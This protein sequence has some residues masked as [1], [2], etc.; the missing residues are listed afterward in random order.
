M[1]AHY[2]SSSPTS[3]CPSCGLR[4]DP[5]HHK[6][7]RCGQALNDAPGLIYRH[8]ADGTWSLVR[9]IDLASFAPQPAPAPKKRLS[10]RAAML[11]LLLVVTGA[12]IN[13][14]LWRRR[15]VAGR[16]ESNEISYYLTHPVGT[17]APRFALQY[18][19]TEQGQLRMAGQTNLPDG[20][21]LQVEVYAGDLMVAIDF[22][23]AV[24]AGQFQTRAL[25]Q[26]GKPFVLAAYQ[27][28][29]SATFDR[30]SQPP[31]VLLVVGERGERLRGPLIHRVDATSGATLRYVENFSLSQ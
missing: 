10:R 27:A 7:T 4:Q 5:G 31:P 16:G 6:C 20:T 25:L 19:R 1:P 12:T 14:G 29:L 15:V 17:I 11:I 24:F 21:D 26:R 28:R 8:E 22:P 3:V 13:L 30:R 9:D 2:P 18:R 23:V